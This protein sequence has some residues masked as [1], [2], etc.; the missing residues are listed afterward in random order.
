MSYFLTTDRESEV[1]S[2]F[3]SFLLLCIFEFCGF[4]ITVSTPKPK[5]LRGMVT[6]WS[7]FISLFLLFTLHKIDCALDLIYAVLNFEKLLDIKEYI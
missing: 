3:F 6:I 2:L 5:P 1:V 4:H 7:N